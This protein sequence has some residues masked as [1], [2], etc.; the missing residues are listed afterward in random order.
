MMDSRSTNRAMI[1]VI[2]KARGR[3]E[4]R[5]GAQLMSVALMA[6]FFVALMGSLAAGAI[7]YRS[8]VEA[9]EEANDLHLQSGLITNVVRYNDVAAALRE[10]DGPE[11]P[12]LVLSRTLASGTYETRIYHYQGQVLQEFAAAG[13]PFDPKGAT[14]LMQT[15]EFSFEVHDD[16][17][18]FTT[19]RGSF[20]VTLRADSGDGAETAAT[21]TDATTAP[22]VVTIMDEGGM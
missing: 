11:G 21:P 8:A 10:A 12:A 4:R 13:R 19:D 18:T 2:E 14:P 6:V 3:Q 15:E 1:S 9:Q 5:G 17:L 22:N 7:M 20:D 16:L